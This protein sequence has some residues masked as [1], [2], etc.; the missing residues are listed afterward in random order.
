LGSP[1]GAIK[2][3]PALKAITHLLFI[4][5]FG[6]YSG[7]TVRQKTDETLTEIKRKSNT[8]LVYLTHY[9][10]PIGP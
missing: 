2:T 3:N 8:L 6:Y 10:V 7:V 4:Y 1:S 9:D 5:F